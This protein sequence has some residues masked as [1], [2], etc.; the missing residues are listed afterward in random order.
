M[1][2]KKN[3]NFDIIVFQT[4]KFKGIKKRIKKRLTYIHSECKYNSTK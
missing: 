4:K 1:F 2:N 3:M